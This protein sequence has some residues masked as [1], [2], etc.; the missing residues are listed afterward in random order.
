MLCLVGAGIYETMEMSNSI[1]ILNC[2][3]KIY[4]ERFTSPI[5]DNFIRI[6]KSTLGPGKKIEIVKRWF[7]EDGRQILDE[8]KRLNVGLISYGDPTIATTFTELRIRAMK[9]NI[10]VKVVHAASGITS[11]IGE[12][13]L[14]IYKIG[15]LVTMMEEKQSA[16]SVYSTVFS[17]LNLNCHTIILT[18]YRQNE[19][20]SE[21]F[22]KPNYVM[23]KILEVEKDI[24]YEIV[25]EI[26]FLIVVSRIGAHDQK[27]VSGKIRSLIDLEHG[28][29]PHSIIFPAKLHFTEE[30]AIM[31]LTNII[32][33]PTD[34]TSK[35]KSVS[36]YMLNKYEPM[37][38]NEI[39]QI[40]DTIG[41]KRERNAQL[42]LLA[43]AEFYL[44][45]AVQFLRQGRKELAILS[46]GYADG[47]I[48]SLKQ[49]LEID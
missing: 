24:T 33:A 32:D 26:S 31:K 18:E 16:I 6:L 19:D 5:S 11:L 23:S 14:Q 21:F 40:R 10:E 45:D 42:E 48:D 1:K 43:N 15:K 8:S 7:V 3:D 39:R 41:S 36:A 44:D 37:I 35:I 2:C 34:N 4:L 27:I 38:R 47:L 9:N 49:I 17:N 30:E 13:G 29:G 28:E 25:S 22:L 12:C 20:G 46:V